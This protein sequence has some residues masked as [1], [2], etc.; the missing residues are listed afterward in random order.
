MKT[1]K[2]NA[3]L[4]Y[5]FL[6]YI[7]CVVF[8]ISCFRKGSLFEFISIILLTGVTA[9]LYLRFRHT[10]L[11]RLYH[12][13]NRDFFEEL[14]S[15]FKRNGKKTECG[16]ADRG[17]YIFEEDQEIRIVYYLPF[18][19]KRAKSFRRIRQFAEDMN[20][21]AVKYDVDY[22]ILILD[23]RMEWYI[24]IFQGFHPECP[25]IE[26]WERRSVSRVLC[27]DR[28]VLNEANR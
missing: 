8:L 19:R 1:R 10:E 16:K 6:R 26:F 15:Y 24:R 9:G 18:Q 20:D 28:E 12:C 14:L 5:L 21:L 23:T 13:S 4:A 3:E 7:T 11:Y 27:N 17:F 25:S 2:L 22:L